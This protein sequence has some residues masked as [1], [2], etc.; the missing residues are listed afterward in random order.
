MTH[1]TSAFRLHVSLAAVGLGA[2][3]AAL[4]AAMRGVSL[5]S[6]SQMIDACR[7]LLFA[8]PDAHSMLVVLGSLSLAVVALAA[9]SIVR[10]WR[11]TRRF[12]RRL[13][14]VDERWLGSEQI[15]VV[16]ADCPQAFCVGL[17][18]PRIYLAETTISTLHEDELLAVV[19]HEAHHVRNRDPLRIFILRVLSDSLF[20][21]PGLGKVGDGYA[22]LAE[23]DAD[24]AAVRGAAGDPRPLAGALVAFEDDA[25]APAG[26]A[27]ERV[28][29]LCGRSPTWRIPVAVSVAAGVIAT[30]IVALAAMATAAADT[31]VSLPALVAHACLLIAA[32]APLLGVRAAWR[33][34][35]HTRRS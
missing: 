6:P 3:A 18:R 23:L 34:R 27:P 20:F 22:S 4:A 14:V 35:A 24:R 31:P 1:A 19:A 8:K 28:D 11:R 12:V 7:S 16:S 21:L 2:T 15:R 9:R 33:R 10:Q 32:F 26:I 29:H 13:N 5:E 17:I 30:T 25:R